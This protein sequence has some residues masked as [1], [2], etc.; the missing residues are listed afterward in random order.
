MIKKYARIILVSLGRVVFVLRAGFTQN[1]FAERC[2]FNYMASKQ[3][4]RILLAPVS[5]ELS[6]KKAL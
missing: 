3:D 4:I 2:V 5:P 1:I 6:N